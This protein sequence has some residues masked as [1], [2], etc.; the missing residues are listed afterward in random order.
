MTDY[1]IYIF[2]IFS[3]TFDLNFHILKKLYHAVQMPQLT[4][5]FKPSNQQ[6]GMSFVVIM[7]CLDKISSFP[8]LQ[9]QVLRKNSTTNHPPICDNLANVQ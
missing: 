8:L 6:N 3:E 4:Q 5:Q 9:I 1:S 7:P 2:L